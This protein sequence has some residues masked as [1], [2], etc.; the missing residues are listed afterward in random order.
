MKT[1]TWDCGQLLFFENIACVE[2]K[3][4]VGFLPDLI[5][6]SSLDPADNG[7][8]K[9][10]AQEAK[11]RL[12]RKCQNYATVGVCNWMVAENAA[13]PFCVSCRLDTVIPDLTVPQNVV[14]WGLMEAAK[15]R[16]VYSS[17][18]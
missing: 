13:E 6:I 2:C 8:Y 12:Y 9:P 14:L 1:S 17:L 18:R 4:E 15:R 10:T 3:R 7:L 11:D 5:C 16:L